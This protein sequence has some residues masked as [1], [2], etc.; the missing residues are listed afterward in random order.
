MA[1]ADLSFYRWLDSFFV[2]RNDG[3]LDEPFEPLPKR[4]LVAMAGLLLGTCRK[5]QKVVDSCPVCNGCCLSVACRLS[6]SVCVI[7]R[8]ARSRHCS[9]VQQREI[10][11]CLLQCGT[12][13][14]GGFDGHGNRDGSTTSHG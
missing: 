5:R 8:F 6:G 3:F 12:I 7:C 10:R 1:A 11:F 4:R 2:W 9:Y 14:G 13:I